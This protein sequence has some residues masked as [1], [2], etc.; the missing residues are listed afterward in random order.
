IKLITTNRPTTSSPAQGLGPPLR[1]VRLGD[2]AQRAQRDGL[3]ARRLGILRVYR[4]RLVIRGNGLLVA[5]QSPKG[6]ALVAPGDRVVGVEGQRLALRAP[7]LL[8]H[9]MRRRSAS[10]VLCHFSY[11]RVDC[12]GSRSLTWWEARAWLCT[13]PSSARR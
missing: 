13:R 11:A 6:V 5:L 1:L 3:V 12:D 9:R 10:R 7:D 4:Q 8:T 2:P